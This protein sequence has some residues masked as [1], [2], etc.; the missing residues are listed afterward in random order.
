MHHIRAGLAMRPG[1][2][3]SGGISKTENKVS[4]NSRLKITKYRTISTIKEIELTGIDT[5][6]EY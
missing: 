5:H 3:N 2:A 1:E 4:T 6:D